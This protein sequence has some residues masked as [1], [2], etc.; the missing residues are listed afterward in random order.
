MNWTLPDSYVVIIH[1]NS[2]DRIATGRRNNTYKH[3]DVNKK[4]TPV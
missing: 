1:Y 2:Q 4:E 3:I